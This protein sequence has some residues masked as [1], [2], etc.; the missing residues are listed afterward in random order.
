MT[1]VPD[2]AEL[3]RRLFDQLSTK[4]GGA[5][6]EANADAIAYVAAELYHRE[7][8]P[9]LWDEK[10]AHEVLDALGA[11]RAGVFAPYSLR[12]RLLALQRRIGTP[13]A[14]RRG[15][16]LLNSLGVPSE[17]ED[18]AELTLRQRIDRL[19]SAEPLVAVVAAAPPPSGNGAGEPVPADVGLVD[20]PLP[21][22]GE[23]VA[24]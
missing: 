19:R 17:D 10:S 16:E 7:F 11:P 6:D 9:H 12:E 13:E 21:E 23:P 4:F 24:G 18:G 20:E 22:T 8:E 14:V 15:H 5:I 3:Y 2:M 1:Q